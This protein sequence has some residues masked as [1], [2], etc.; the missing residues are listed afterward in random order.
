VIQAVQKR[1][2]VLAAGERAEKPFEL[3]LAGKATSVEVTLGV[4]ASAT[5]FD[6][7]TSLSHSVN[8]TLAPKSRLT[9]I[10]L[11]EGSARSLTSSVAEDAFMHWHCTTIGGGSDAH[12]LVSRC[13]G[14]H[15]TSTVD[16]IFAVKGTEKQSVDVRNVFDATNGAGEI[17]LKGIAE[18][19]ALAVCNGMIEITERGRGTDTYLT[20]D[21][22]ML[23]S[24]AKVDAIPGLEIRT[25]D[26]KAS[27]SATVSRVTAE[28]LF[29]LQSR[30]I[31]VLTARRMFVDG[32]LAGLAESISHTALRE[33]VLRVLH[34]AR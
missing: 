23:D 19:K 26:V 13:I 6:V 21:V 27:H 16:W 9:Y 15:A 8:V 20:E 28:D 2:I 17:T 12:T 32:F 34:Q 22:L 33:N 18:E 5:I 30:G 3:S 11:S 31:D 10:S 4:G 25:N 7:S 24:T 29:Y 14:P 1:H